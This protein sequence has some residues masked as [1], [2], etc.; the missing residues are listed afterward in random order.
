MPR[1]LVR[2]LVCG[3]VAAIPGQSGALGRLSVALDKLESTEQ[4]HGGASLESGDLLAPLLLEAMGGKCYHPS[5]IPG[6]HG[7]PGDYDEIH[8]QHAYSG[9][10]NLNGLGSADVPIVP[11][12]G[13]DLC[14][15]TCHCQLELHNVATSKAG[16]Q[17][18]CIVT[19]SDSY[20]ASKPS[21]NII[22]NGFFLVRRTRHVPITRS[23]FD[24]CRPSCTDQYE[25]HV[26]GR[27]RKRC[28]H[29]RVRPHAG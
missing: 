28:C 25:G 22:K 19:A 16:H 9:Y 27:D 13:E 11:A 18:D 10:S 20:Q 23:R 21:A 15:E 26:R 2:L 12:E 17:I 7:V 5:E 6:T 1:H 8:F 3:V 14:C 4:L 24:A 29:R